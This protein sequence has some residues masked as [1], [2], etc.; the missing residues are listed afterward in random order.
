V[1][2]AQAP[3]YEGQVV[4]KK[5]G[6]DGGLFVVNG[7]G[8]GLVRLTADVYDDFPAW[9]PDGTQVAFLSTR[10]NRRSFPAVYVMNS[11]GTGIHRVSDEYDF[12]GRPTWSPG[13]SQIALHRYTKLDRS[14]SEIVLINSDGTGAPTPITSSTEY[15]VHP[16][17][18]PDGGAS[19]SRRIVLEAGISGR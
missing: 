15:N 3:P 11:D 12:Q 7:D 16:S 4:Y 14:R 9:S 17:W 18:S 8:T 6:D 13:G 1:N 10:E 5:E 19:S 2:A